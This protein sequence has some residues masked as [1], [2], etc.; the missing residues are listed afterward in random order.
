MCVGVSLFLFLITCAVCLF[1]TEKAQPQLQNSPIIIKSVTLLVSTKPV[2]LKLNSTER[3]S[4]RGGGRE[5]KDSQIP[6]V[7]DLDSSTA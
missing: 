7:V 4:N 5:K 2:K 6:E 1:L 3:E